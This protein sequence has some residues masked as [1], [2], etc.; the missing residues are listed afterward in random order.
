MG[1]LT[2][3]IREWLR[4][5]ERGPLLYHVGLLAADRETKPRTSTSME[6]DNRA[7][8]LHE[9]ACGLDI[10]KFRDDPEIILYQRKRKEHEYEYWAA[11]ANK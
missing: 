4:H 3:E 10:E 7:A 6:L 9:L 11:H 1:T 2:S 8:E 5:R